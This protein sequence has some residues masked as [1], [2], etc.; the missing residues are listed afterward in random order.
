MRPL[1]GRINTITK[2]TPWIW[3]P[4]MRAYERISQRIRASSLKPGSSRTR[5]EDK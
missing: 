5:N 4:A 1:S 2:N 3:A